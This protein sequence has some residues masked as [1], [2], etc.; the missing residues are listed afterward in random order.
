MEIKTK[1]ITF[2]KRDTFL[3]SLGINNA[4]SPSNGYY[5]NIPATAVVYILDTKEIWTHGVFIASA[6]PVFTAATSTANGTSGLVP[7]P[8]STNYSER[9][10]R[11]LRSDAT[12]AK[13]GTMVY[14]NTTDYYTKSEVDD[15]NVTSVSVSSINLTNNWANLY[16]MSQLV[17]GSYLIQTVYEGRMYT[18]YFSQ[19]KNGQNTDDEILLHM[20]GNTETLA[21]G[22][23]G[24]LYLKVK[25]VNNKPYLQASAAVAENNAKLTIKFKKLI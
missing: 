7:A 4:T 23:R 19:I 1:F 22:T 11:F 12:W 21:D 17:D 3:G 25:S 5:G 18:G 10:Y 15:L 2:D 8:T 24:R 14:A 20:A 13:V 6:T 16:D 9:T